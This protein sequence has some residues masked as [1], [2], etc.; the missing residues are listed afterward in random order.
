LRCAPSG[1]RDVRIKKNILWNLKIPIDVIP[2]S[3]YLFHV[4]SGE[5]RFL[6]A[7][8]QRTER[9]LA[10]PGRPGKVDAWWLVERWEALRLA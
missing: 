7:I 3:Q 9:K 5:D 4:L 1:L 8:F 6:E 2:T 10:G